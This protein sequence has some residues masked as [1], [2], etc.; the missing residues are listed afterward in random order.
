MEPVGSAGRA[1]L[2][3]WTTGAAG[4]G[5]GADGP[6]RPDDAGLVAA[7]RWMGGPTGGAVAAGAPDAG[8]E[9]VR[10]G[11]GTGTEVEPSGGSTAGPA[12]SADAPEPGRRWTAGAGAVAGVPGAGAVAGAPGATGA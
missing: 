8:A 12:P 11:F 4:T 7:S 5:T 1:A 9:P 10:L 2:E 6:D 3:R